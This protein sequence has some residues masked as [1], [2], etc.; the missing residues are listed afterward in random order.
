MKPE[1]AIAIS[2]I[3]AAVWLVALL[4]E[5]A[6]S[7]HRRLYC[8]HRAV[9]RFWF[10]RHYYAIRCKLCGREIARGRDVGHRAPDGAPGVRRG[11]R[12]A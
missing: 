11:I 10:P 7:T 6:V 8:D 9:T 3:L 1:T 4:V 12:A 2:V 5:R